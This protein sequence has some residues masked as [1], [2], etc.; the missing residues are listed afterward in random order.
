MRD[1]SPRFAEWLEKY[2]RFE[3]EAVQKLTALFKEDAPK[4][5]RRRREPKTK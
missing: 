4:A 2:R 5:R 1:T 3:I